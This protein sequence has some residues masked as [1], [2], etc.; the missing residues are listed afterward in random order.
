MSEKRITLHLDLT[1]TEAAALYRLCDK[2]SYQ[3]ARS[4][5]YAHLP[6]ATLDR[7]TSEILNAARLVERDLANAGVSAHPW[8]AG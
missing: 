8:V 3:T 4:V 6:K 2:V 5:L 7:Q 1:Q